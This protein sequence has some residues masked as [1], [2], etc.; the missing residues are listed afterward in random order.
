[1]KVLSTFAT[2]YSARR[3]LTLMGCACLG[4]LLVELALPVLGFLW[5][6]TH[7]DSIEWGEY[8]FHVPNGFFVVHSGSDKHPVMIRF[9][10]AIP[11]WPYH[12]RIAG[13]FARE[14][15]ISILGKQERYTEE[16][17]Y[18]PGYSIE[19]RYLAVESGFVHDAKS[20]GL[21]LEARVTGAT[22]AGEAV[23]L[24]FG[25]R[26]MVRLRCYF[27]KETMLAVFYDGEREF[28]QAVYSIVR[29]VVPGK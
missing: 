9:T 7:H 18:V 12:S 3:V 1:M 17:G 29:E 16:R 24:Q 11:F 13:R 25:G 22:A 19:R 4:I 14:S 15:M 21:T 5:H 28:G 26:G 23:C 27:K 6:S 8:R 10:P 20:D 2:R